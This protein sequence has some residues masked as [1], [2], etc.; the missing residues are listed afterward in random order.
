MDKPEENIIVHV[1]SQNA[2]LIELLTGWNI[3][4][5]QMLFKLQELIDNENNNLKS[6]ST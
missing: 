4:Y 6:K 3:L 1:E 5:V 2:S